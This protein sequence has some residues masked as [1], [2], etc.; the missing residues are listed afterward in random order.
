MNVKTTKKCI[1]VEWNDVLFSGVAHDGH[2]LSTVCF[3][4]WQISEV[5]SLQPRLLKFP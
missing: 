1:S 3:T 4:L 2:L 5:S